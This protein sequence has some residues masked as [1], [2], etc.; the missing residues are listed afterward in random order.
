[1]ELPLDSRIY[2][3]TYHRKCFGYLI[4]SN[5]EIEEGKLRVEEFYV[6]EPY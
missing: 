6:F 3:K 2:M 5:D 1:M 4:V